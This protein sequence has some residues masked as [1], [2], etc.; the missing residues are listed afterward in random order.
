MTMQSNRTK[1]QWEYL[2]EY[3]LKVAP[4]LS[5]IL[6]PSENSWAVFDATVIE[7]CIVFESI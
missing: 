6:R 7:I 3:A 2:W 1:T 5:E 4:V